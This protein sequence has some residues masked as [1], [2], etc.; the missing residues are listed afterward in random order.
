VAD[1]RDAGL[2]IRVPELPHLVN[3]RR[4]PAVGLV[5]KRAF[6]TFL[7]ALPKKAADRPD[8]ELAHDLFDNGEIRPV[9]PPIQEAP[10]H[11]ADNPDDVLTEIER[12]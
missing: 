10:D 7:H 4:A 11:R 2:L 3:Q 5:L 6:N 12:A 9:I 1:E 8:V